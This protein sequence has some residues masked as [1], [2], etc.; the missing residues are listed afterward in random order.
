MKKK[1]TLKPFILMCLAI[2]S[3]NCVA[4]NLGFD[5]TFKYIQ[6]TFKGKVYLSETWNNDYPS[7]GDGHTTFYEHDYALESINECEV[8]LSGGLVM[9]LMGEKRLSE[10]YSFDLSAVKTIESVIDEHTAFDGTTFFKYR[11][12]FDFGIDAPKDFVQ[13]SKM[14]RKYKFVTVTNV[15]NNRESYQLNFSLI[16]ENNNQAERLTRAFRNL[17]NTCTNDPFAGTT[18]GSNSVYSNVNNGNTE[19]NSSTTYNDTPDTIATGEFGICLT[20]KINN[21]TANEGCHQY[22]KKGTQLCADAAGEICTSNSREELCQKVG[23]KVGIPYQYWSSGWG[24]FPSLGRCMQK[25]G[26][27]SVKNFGGKCSDLTMTLK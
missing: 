18:S 12:R 21:F 11:V 8:F 19:H 10:H 16:L 9:P 22:F 5:E 7:K 3:T 15:D 26:R 4:A 23:E 2:V 13:K 25:C 27:D 24:T 20:E 17:Q 1:Q 6:E 14:A